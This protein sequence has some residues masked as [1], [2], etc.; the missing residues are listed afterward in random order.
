[1]PTHDTKMKSVNVRVSNRPSL[2][3]RMQEI[4][5]LATLNHAI[6]Q[7]ADCFDNCNRKA[8]P[9]SV[10]FRQAEACE[11]DYD[12][13]DEH[14]TTIVYTESF[15]ANFTHSGLDYLKGAVAAVLDTG[16]AV[17][18]SSLALTRSLIEASATCSWLVD[19]ELD[20]DTRLRRTNQ[21]LVRD[22]KE[23]LRILPDGTETTPRLVSVDP[24]LK[25]E[26]EK[27]RDAALQWARAQ[28]WKCGKDKEI[29]L[30]RWI[31]EIPS[32]TEAVAL[33]GQGQS[34]G[35]WVDLY[36]M[37]S[38]VTHSQTP[39]MLL[40]NKDESDSFFDRALMVLE[41]GISFY[42]HALRQY[43]EFM[44]WHD[45]DIDGWFGLVH[46][47]VQHMRNP[48]EV[49]LPVAQVRPDRCAICPDYQDPG[50]HRLALVSHLC[51][52]FE[53]YIANENTGGAE[54]PMLYSS[55][56]DFLDQFE[57]A[58]NNGNAADPK[59]QGMRSAY[60]SGHLGVLQLLGSDSGEVATSIA[61]SWAVLRSQSYQ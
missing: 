35:Y 13:I 17:R 27:V 41:I 46:K 34:P 45:H 7:V 22:C 36:S 38:G 6:G 14:R 39:L 10:S 56:M 18:W 60:G 55:A 8:E 24:I 21:M 20:L 47:T 49:S 28:G 58:I 19:P 32:H 15:A 48:E 3:D 26:C 43:A 44:G 42:T 23:I 4:T 61:A 40:A 12:A 2:V 11:K 31:G 51:A 29:S 25:A 1:M 52:L 59:I 5:L 16:S 53:H 9:G 30:R 33:A 57:C 50:M 37:L 54:A